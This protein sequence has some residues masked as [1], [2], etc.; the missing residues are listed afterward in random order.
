M[1]HRHLLAAGLLSLAA[2]G[3]ARA[4]DFTITADGLW[5]PFDVSDLESASH[6]LEWITLGDGSA[7]T[8]T[9]TIDAG[10]TAILT[11][12]DT[13][14]A[15]DRFNVYANAT[16]LGIT[17]E[18]VD[19]APN[20]VG[21]DAFDAALADSNYS[22]GVYSFSAG[23]YTVTGDLARSAL[24]GG[25]VLNATPGA[26][27]LEIAAVPELSTGAMLLAGMA[28]MGLAGRRGRAAARARMG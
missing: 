6:G 11:V 7:A 10:Q 23:T 9:F 20:S 28:A 13:Q 16:L 15:G 24:F 12:V 3:G 18:G 5:N 21:R 1:H 19:T 4:N 22:R 2:L 8:F 26:V 27:K 14:Y 25:F 17:S